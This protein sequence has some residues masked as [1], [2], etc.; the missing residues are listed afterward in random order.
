VL[1]RERF[2]D[3]IE[4]A[5]LVEDDLASIG[6][7]NKGVLNV[8]QLQSGA[9]VRRGGFRLPLDR[10]AAPGRAPLPCRRRL[11]QRRPAAVR[12][13]DPARSAE[14]VDALLRKGLLMTPGP[15]VKTLAKQAGFNR[16]TDPLHDGR[17]L[18]HPLQELPHETFLFD[19]AEFMAM[20]RR[21]SVQHSTYHPPKEPEPEAEPEAEPESG[22][23]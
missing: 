16:S 4:A 20:V 17:A 21:S 6:G 9:H 11:T 3:G 15:G 23:L 5:L 14:E 8:A 22:L 1:S 19:I 12:R 10:R 2:F 7:E 13:V 18:I